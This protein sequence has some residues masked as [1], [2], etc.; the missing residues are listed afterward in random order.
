MKFA[1]RASTLAV[2][3]ITGAQTAGAQSDPALRLPPP[4]A[5]TTIE[6][7]G[8]FGATTRHGEGWVCVR[9]AR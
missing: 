8:V 3:V 5:Q 9:R 2:L 6:S 7:F 1:V 4:T